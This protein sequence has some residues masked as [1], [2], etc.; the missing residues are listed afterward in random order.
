MRSRR[1]RTAGYDLSGSGYLAFS[2]HL[3]WHPDAHVNSTLGLSSLVVKTRKGERKK[4][5][6]S[7]DFIDR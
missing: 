5:K 2:S 4:T 6:P 1:T 3:V 7:V